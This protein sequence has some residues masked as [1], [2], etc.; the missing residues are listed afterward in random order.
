[1]QMLHELHPREKKV[2]RGEYR[3]LVGGLEIDYA[4]SWLVTRLP[5]GQQVIRAEV[6]GDSGGEQAHLLTHMVRDADEL[7]TWLRM[8]Y[9]RGAL[10]GAVQYTFRPATVQ[11]ARQTWGLRPWQEVVDI[12]EGYEIDY[13]P[14]IGRD[15]VWRAYPPNEQMEVRSLP[16]FSPDLWTDEARLLTGRTL[17]YNVRLEP[18]SGCVVPAGQFRHAEHFK[19][20]LSDGERAEAW[21]DEEGVPLRWL[22][23]DKDYDFVLTVYERFE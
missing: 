13:P 12:A 17:R 6:R 7:P 21:Y 11:I 15:Y 22:Y 20:T 18:D 9:G 2:C 16:V 14:I 19:L 4:E 23:P 8:R 1:M 3:C 5:N 10:G